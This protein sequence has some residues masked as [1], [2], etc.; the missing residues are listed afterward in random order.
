MKAPGMESNDANHSSTDDLDDKDHDEDS[1]A[2]SKD[3]TIADEEHDNF[4]MHTRYGRYGAAYNMIGLCCF[5]EELS[6]LPKNPTEAKLQATSTQGEST[7]P[8]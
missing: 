7:E 6:L 8:T 1:S 4:R 2:K 3:E 5:N